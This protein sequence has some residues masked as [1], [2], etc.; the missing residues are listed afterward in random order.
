LEFTSKEVEELNACPNCGTTNVPMRIEHDLEI[1]INIHELRIL[2]IWAENHAVA[3]DQRNQDTPGYESMKKT[4]NVIA[5]LLEKQIQEKT[6]RF[7]PLTLTHELKELT[8]ELQK[9]G[10]M[11][12]PIQLFRGGKEEM[13]DDELV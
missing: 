7:V 8:G 12:G 10:I 9:K 3:C 4:V 2:G 11:H 5:D 1:K 13:I 6:G